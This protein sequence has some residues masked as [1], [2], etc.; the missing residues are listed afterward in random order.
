MAEK[1]NS[2]KI[3][4]EKKAPAKKNSGAVK[5]YFKELKGEFKKITWPTAA[6]LWKNTGATIALCAI[7]GVI[8]CLIDLGLDGLINLLL[9]L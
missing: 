5:R 2:A 7:V 3:A 6:A 4:S 8:V 9:S 1:T